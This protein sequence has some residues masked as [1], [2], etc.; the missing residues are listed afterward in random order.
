MDH[1]NYCEGTLH[2]EKVK[3]AALAQL[4]GTPCYVYSRAS[5]KQHWRAFASALEN[6]PHLICYAVKANSNLGV[7]NVLARLG[8]GFD[9]VSG[10]ELERVLQAG[11]LPHKVVFSGVGKTKAEMQFALKV[12]IYC[13]NVESMPE[14]LRLNQVAGEMGK[15]ATISL[16]IN[17][18]VNA[19]THPYISTGLKQN[20]FGI[21]IEMALQAYT[22]A[23]ALPHLNVIGITFHIGSQLTE[24]EP[25]VDALQRIMV[26]IEQ[27]RG[28]G[29]RLRHINVGG[30]LGVRYQDEAPPEPHAY[31]QALRR[32]LGQVPYKILIEPG[33]AI[34]AN[35]GVLLTKVEYLKH[36]TTKNF[37]IVD[38]AM[39]DLIRPALYGAWHDILPVTPRTEIP[40]MSYDIVGPVCETADFLGKERLLALQEGDLLA[41]C[42]SGAYGFVMSSNYNSR[43]RPIELMVDEAQV[44]V[45]RKRETIEHL[46]AL[47]RI[48]TN[49]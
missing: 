3:L 20:K 6:R 10:G 31:A 19:N 40:A 48:W 13:F 4:Y 28:L 27:L 2:A 33:R 29:I 12:G 46:L 47:E 44:Q 22:K 18:D 14:L 11:G 30:G 9:I 23:V 39:T 32:V 5:L 38:A 45:V 17:P 34:V 8:S 21:D 41:V 42:S 15:K 25:F 24:L 7:L 1:F 49:Q 36:T 37:A 16:R 35:A 43:L 26:L